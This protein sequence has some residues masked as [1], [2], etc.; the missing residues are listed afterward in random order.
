MPI[1]SLSKAYT[2]FD[3]FKDST[4]FKLREREIQNKCVR[5]RERE[6]EAKSK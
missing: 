6:R 4:R 5:E 1:Q 3:L 2:Q